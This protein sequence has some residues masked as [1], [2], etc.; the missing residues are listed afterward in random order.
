MRISA[1][2]DYAVRALVEI[3]RRGDGDP[4]TTEDVGRKQD[5][6]K[7]FLSVILADLRRAGIVASQRGQAGGWRLARKPA[8]VTMADIFRAVDG[9]LAS[10]ADRR[11]EA[12]EYEESMAPLKTVWIALRSS[13]RDV[14]EAITLADLA[15]GDL[16]ENVLARTRDPEAWNPH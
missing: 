3:A 8:D 14:L 16:P 10:V 1:K 11:P 15:S 6:P 9:P 12:V 5:I 7:A 2:A 13:L 4:T